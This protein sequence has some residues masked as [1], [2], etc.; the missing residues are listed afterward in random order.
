[1]SD[2]IILMTDSYKLTH[3]KQYPENTEAVYSYFES[4]KG[5]QFPFTVFFGLQYILDHLQGV[6]VSWDSIRYAE[7]I[8]TAHLG[9]GYFNRDGWEHILKEHGGELPL[10]IT[11][12]PEGSIIPTGNVLMTVENTDPACYWLT[13]YVETLLTHVWY[14]STVATLSKWVKNQYESYLGATGDTSGIDFMLHDFGFRGASS[15]ETAGI[16]GAAHLVNFK[17][18]DTLAALEV[19]IDYYDADLSSLAFSVPATEHSIM[20]SLGKFGEYKILDNILAAYPTGIVS[21]VADSYNIYKFTEAVIKRKDQILNRDGRFVLR[22]D[23]ITHDHPSAPELMM[24]IVRSLW[25]GFGGHENS[26]G[27]KVLDDHIRVIWGDGIDHNGIV[28]VLR[29][30]KDAGFSADNFVFGMGGGLLQKINRDTQRFA[31]KSSAQKRDGIW[32]DVS[33]APLDASKAS[34]AGRLKLV[35]ENGYKTVRSE[36]TGSKDDL[37]VP[38]FEN[39]EILKRYTFDEIRENANG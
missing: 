33:K 8:V 39:G 28:S 37:L 1:M 35:R 32:Y 9:P 4:R 24:W 26:K 21:V 27:Y 19:A 16:G 11:A 38:V 3:Y 5:A 13:N 31:F 7:E 22:P 17:G 30:A 25:D 36:E 23:S 10:R 12:V 20:T 2:S 15:L 6:Q 34:K 18:T 29:H 14:G